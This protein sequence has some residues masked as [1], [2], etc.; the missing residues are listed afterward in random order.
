MSIQNFPK[1]PKI[2]L[3]NSCDE[4]KDPKNKKVRFFY[5][6]PTDL[7]L[8]QPQLGESFVKQHLCTRKRAATR[9]FS[10]QNERLYNFGFEKIYRQNGFK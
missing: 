3:R 5:A 8:R 10:T 2:T 9:L 6:K 1:I 4:H 7:D